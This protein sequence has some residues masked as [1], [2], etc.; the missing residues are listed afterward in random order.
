METLIGV[1]E[2]RVCDL[3]DFIQVV[4]E[5]VTVHEEGIGGGDGIPFVH[6]VRKQ[7]LAIRCVVGDI[8]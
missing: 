1:I 3:G 4:T 2:V 5:G 8:V 7:R 6:K